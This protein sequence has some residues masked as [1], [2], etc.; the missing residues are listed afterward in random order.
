MELTKLLCC[1]WEVA[2]VPWFAG[3]R[4]ALAA[5]M[6]QEER[7]DCGREGRSRWVQVPMRSGVSRAEFVKA[8]AGQRP[9]A[10]ARGVVAEGRVCSAGEGVGRA[11]KAKLDAV[12]AGGLRVCLWVACV[13]H[14]LC[15]CP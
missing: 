2:F 1:G 12:R 7:G 10:G 11:E 6:P 14:D 5:G 4:G 9:K 8:A 15:V 3:G 13:S